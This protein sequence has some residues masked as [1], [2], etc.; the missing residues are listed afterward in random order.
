MTHRH[1][2]RTTRDLGWWRRRDLNPRPSRC[3]R[4]VLCF[5]SRDTGRHDAPSGDMVGTWG[6]AADPVSYAVACRPVHFWQQTGNGVE[7]KR[8]RSPG[9]QCDLPFRSWVE[10]IGSTREALAFRAPRDGEKRAHAASLTLPGPPRGDSPV[11]VCVD[12]S[13]TL[14]LSAASSTLEP[15]LEPKWGGL[16]SPAQL[17]T[18]L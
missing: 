4:G 10:A 18:S 16:P 1:K 15:G 9:G 7:P 8:G 12:C 6:H 2:S 17:G 11:R 14:D 3:E 13:S 5:E